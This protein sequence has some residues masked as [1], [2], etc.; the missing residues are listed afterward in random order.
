MS[1]NLFFVDLSLRR[2]NALSAPRLIW[3]LGS[4]GVRIR[5]NFPIERALSRWRAMNAK[6]NDGCPSAEERWSVIVGDG[7]RVLAL[8]EPGYDAPNFG[9][10]NRPCYLSFSGTCTLFGCVGFRSTLPVCRM[11]SAVLCLF[12]H[13]SSSCNWRI[14]KR[15]NEIACYCAF[16]DRF[17]RTN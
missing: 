7:E 1:A 10:E 14:N 17:Q 9:Y 3:L 4:P 13:I 15:R 2:S 8:L 5:P 12:L 6:G 16:H 11:M